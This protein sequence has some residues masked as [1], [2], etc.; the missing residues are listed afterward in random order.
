MDCKKI[1]EY[2]QSKRKGKKLTQA[3][4][5]EML[6][7]TSKAV[8]K[9][10]TGVA[11]PDV[12]LFPEL[13]KIL[14]ITIEELLN[15]QDNKKIPIDKKKNYMIISLSVLMTLLIIIFTSIIVYFKNNYSEVEI[16]KLESARED[17]FVEGTLM[18][19]DGKNYISIAK[20]DY[21][22][23]D[24]DIFSSISDFEYEL[25]LEDDLLY[26]SKSMKSVDVNNLKKAFSSI[27]VY[28][29]VSQ[30]II[31]D[32]DSF[33]LKIDYSNEQNINKNYDLKIKIVK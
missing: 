12:S 24:H 7:V 11:L 3:Q 33:V 10:E 9:W 5:S 20:V 21:L 26:K 28:V 18:N 19:I 27:Y 30:N 32:S 29:S 8:S 22:G 25:Y 13:T 17:F 6:G 23:K 31:I 16:Y 2:I 4:L 1:G 14:D 15:G